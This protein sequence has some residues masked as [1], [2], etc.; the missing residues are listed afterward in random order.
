MCDKHFLRGVSYGKCSMNFI[1]E[2]LHE[3][4]YC[5]ETRIPSL[6][7]FRESHARSPVGLF[8]CT[9]STADFSGK[10][11]ALQGAFS[12]PGYIFGCQTELCV[13]DATGKQWVE[14]RDATSHLHRT[15]QLPQ[16]RSI[17]PSSANCAT[18]KKKKMDLHSPLTSQVQRLYLPSWL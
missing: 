10:R 6:A 2:T 9:P 5:K 13:C 12:M 11:S 18:V 15:G 17:W 4:S 14:A 8:L 7:E 1:A 16:P 3:Q